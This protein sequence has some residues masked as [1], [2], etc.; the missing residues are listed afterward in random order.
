MKYIFLALL[1][2]ALS[3]C[4]T[5]STSSLS[6]KGAGR[7]IQV[8]Q[9]PSNPYLQIEVPGSKE[10]AVIEVC[11]LKDDNCDHIIANEESISLKGI[12]A[13]S[14]HIT[15]RKC[16]K[17][18]DSTACD[19]VVEQ[20]DYTQSPYP[21]DETSLNVQQEYTNLLRKNELA[22]QFYGA[23]TRL[24]LGMEECRQENGGTLDS[25]SQGYADL[26]REIA[27]LGPILGTATIYTILAQ[28]PNAIAKLKGQSDTLGLAEAEGDTR[29]KLITYLLP[30]QEKVPFFVD[31][32]WKI[33][34]KGLMG[35]WLPMSN[36]HSAI[37]IERYEKGKWKFQYFFSYPG[38]NN[39]TAEMVSSY[40]WR[41]KIETVIPLEKGKVEEF[42]EW[43]RTS[44]WSATPNNPLDQLKKDRLAKKQEILKLISPELV[45]TNDTISD[46]EGKKFSNE[47]KE[48][49]KK[50]QKELLAY[51]KANEKFLEVFA[52]MDEFDDVVN[53]SQVA[54]RIDEINYQ[55][56][57]VK[58]TPELLQ[59]RADLIVEE[60]KNML[61]RM[62][63]GTFRTFAEA[64][65]VLNA[66]HM[67]LVSDF[68]NSR[69]TTW[70]NKWYENWPR[71]KTAKKNMTADEIKKVIEGLREY[72]RIEAA[73]T[74]QVERAT[75]TG[76]RGSLLRLQL[77]QSEA[78]IKKNLFLH[79]SSDLS[80][81]F[82]YTGDAWK[83]API[84]VIYTDLYPELATKLDDPKFTDTDWKAFQKDNG[85]QG[86][87][88]TFD[89]WYLDLRKAISRYE[90]LQAE[91]HP[92]KSTYGAGYSM[93]W[94]NCS[95]ASAN[96]LNVLTGTK[97][98]LRSTDFL[99][100]PG[101]LDSRAK[102]FVKDEPSLSKKVFTPT[103]LGMAAVVGLLTYV[104]VAQTTTGLTDE[105]SQD[106][107]LQQCIADYQEEYFE[108]IDP[109]LIE[110]GRLKM[111]SDVADQL[112]K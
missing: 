10:G 68:E 97:K 96:A 60:R 87:P 47:L 12:P 88:K 53:R 2:L 55:L 75:L 76:D 9:D 25:N 13:G 39:Y 16:K 4:K 99:M 100:T 36:G 81:Y 102:A 72:M 34:W 70:S 7:T 93:I 74:Y 105:A 109:I 110:L 49:V 30:P 56:S 98:F 65:S 28:D 103:N 104:A 8:V 78:F 67:K 66:D 64:Q 85:Y 27:A 91:L 24:Y 33:N 38:G 23:M 29:A 101:T 6:R 90:N 106:G 58:S 35:K 92:K 52:F 108:R 3:A 14:Y 46:A 15:L 37:L 79:E 43:W 84:E 61:V 22:L 45:G 62:T 42:A 86:K 40:S 31:K 32:T 18:N 26:V 63:D 73:T 112:S 59:K 111:S 5:T 50:G 51:Q 21:D 41:K 89:K 54:D 19:E 82:G 44:E 20:I 48:Y 69:N 107:A 17:D 71:F 77:Y 80:K 95:Y 94:K 1:P 57:Q 83:M 11:N